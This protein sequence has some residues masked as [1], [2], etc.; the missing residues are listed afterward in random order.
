MARR[1]YNGAVRNLN[2]MVEVLPE[3]PGRRRVQVRA[4]HDYFEIEDA[5]TARCPRSRSRSCAMLCSPRLAAPR[6]SRA[7]AL[8]LLAAA[9]VSGASAAGSIQSLRFG[10]GGRERRH[11]RR[12]RDDPVRAEGRDQARHLS[13]T[14]R[15]PS[16]T[17]A[18]GCTRSTSS[19]S[20]STR[21]GQPEPYFTAARGRRSS[22]STPATRTCSSRRRLHLCAHATRPTGRSAGSTA[23]PSFSGT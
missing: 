3:Q 15:S 13:A 4:A 16:R 7:D 5:P 9:A 21:D 2:T 12:H 17:P 8:V 6:R 19:L 18:A 14:S 10:R 20:A 23:S 1:Y 22:A 11:A